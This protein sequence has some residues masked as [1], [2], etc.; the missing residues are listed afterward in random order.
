MTGITELTDRDIDA[1]SGGHDCE[2]HGWI[3]E[4]G[5]RVGGWIGRQ[6]E[7][8]VGYFGPRQYRTLRRD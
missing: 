8:A 7:W 3:R 1:V 6:I 5:E 2:D 4:Q